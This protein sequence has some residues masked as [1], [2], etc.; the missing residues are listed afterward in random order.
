MKEIW[1]RILRIISWII[2]V[3]ENNCN[4]NK[5]ARKFKF[6]AFLFVIS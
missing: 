6:L 4:T 3:S 2:V 5:K 1:G